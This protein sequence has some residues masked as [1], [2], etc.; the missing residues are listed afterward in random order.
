MKLDGRQIGY[1]TK[2]R[3]T[4]SG[5]FTS[6][7]S[8]SRKVI[9]GGLFIALEGDTF[10]GH[11]FVVDVLEQGAGGALVSRDVEGVSSKACII[12][13]GNTQRA[14]TALGAAARGHA[15]GTFVVITGSVGKT[16][17]KDM[18]AAALAPF[19]KVGKTPGNLN[20]PI[21]VPLTLI[22]LDGDED[23][24]VLEIGMSAPGEI[25]ALTLLTRP[26]IG[27]VTRA[28]AAHLEFFPDVDAI[29]D[30]KAE[31]YEFLP[32]AAKAIVNGD[33]SRMF[34]RAKAL[35]PRVWSFGRHPNADVGIGAVSYRAG[36]LAVSLDVRGLP[37]EVELASVGLHN[38]EHVAAAMTVV[39]MCHLDLG[40]AAQALGIGFRAGKHRLEVL[41][42]RGRTIL[43]D[44]YNANPASTHA[45]LQAFANMARDISLADRMIVLGTMR[46][47]GPEAANFHRE[48]GLAAA[49][50]ADTIIATGAHAADIAAGAPNAQ[51]FADVEDALALITAWVVAHPGG[52]VLLKGS[53][54]ERLERVLEPIERSLTRHLAGGD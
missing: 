8:D 41:S 21:G 23:F 47:L 33:D 18:T 24:V 40:V 15:A 32:R 51:T 45:A 39:S 2:G 43:D 20:N 37:V 29:A 54:G 7:F 3:V 49:A 1:I 46:E 28:A 48:V 9:P 31:L 53:R 13:V 26:D 12:R 50:L 22:N 14:L 5:S 4:G 16:T 42:V 38:A 10:D 35:V 17:C 34:Q 36:R 19:G 52:A 30:A 44:C 25:A 11:D 27:V 6:Y